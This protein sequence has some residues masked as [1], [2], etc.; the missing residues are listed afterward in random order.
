MISRII[1]IAILVLIG[2]LFICF[3]TRNC[4]AASMAQHTVAQR[5]SRA[6]H[7]LSHA[8]APTA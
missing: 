4:I 6:L 2:F 1:I 3:H 5:S 8:Y 7:L